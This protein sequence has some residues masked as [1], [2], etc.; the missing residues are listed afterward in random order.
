VEAGPLS[1]SSV[2]LCADGRAADTE[3]NLL[4]GH[5]DVMYTHYNYMSPL[6]L[7]SRSFA[8]ICPLRVLQICRGRLAFVQ[9]F[10]NQSD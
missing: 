8:R 6:M 3:R 2:A 1:E 9:F 7:Q 4:L 10:P 5:I